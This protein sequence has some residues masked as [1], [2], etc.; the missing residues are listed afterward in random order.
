MSKPVLYLRDNFAPKSCIWL[1]QHIFYE[2]QSF[3]VDVL[4]I[5]VDDVFL[6][7]DIRVQRILKNH[8]ELNSQVCNIQFNSFVKAQTITIQVNAREKKCKI[9]S[10]TNENT[11]ADAEGG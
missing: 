1:N 8:Q 10:K 2:H 7:Q 9:K 5:T 4:A 6:T 3:V 11:S